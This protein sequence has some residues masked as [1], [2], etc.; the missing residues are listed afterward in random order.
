MWMS[1]IFWLKIQI[2][3]TYCQHVNNFWS[4]SNVKVY[5]H[6]YYIYQTNVSGVIGKDYRDFIAQ[7]YVM[8]IWNNDLQHSFKSVII[9]AAVG[10]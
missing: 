1:C 6:T 5:M 9:K 8:E 3:R 4:P 2:Q 10:D 7:G